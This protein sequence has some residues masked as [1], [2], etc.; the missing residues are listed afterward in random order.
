[1]LK[2]AE[3]VLQLENFSPQ[4]P[5]EKREPFKRMAFQMT[6]VEVF[7]LMRT[8]PFYGENLSKREAR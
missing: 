7:L 4:Y 3:A 1:M 5:Q 6:I 2:T 8:H